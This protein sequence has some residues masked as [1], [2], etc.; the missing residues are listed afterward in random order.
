M[1]IKKRLTTV[2]NMALFGVTTCETAAK[3]LCFK[4]CWF[5]RNGFVDV[6]HLKFG[7]MTALVIRGCNMTRCP[8]LTD[9]L[10]LAD[11]YGF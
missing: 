2:R 10:N 11:L 3:A 4:N 9:E 8:D 7:A 5:D 1:V 6:P